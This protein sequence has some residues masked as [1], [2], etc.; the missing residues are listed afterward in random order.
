MGN[1]EMRLS[2][3]VVCWIRSTPCRGYTCSPTA[4]D[5][6]VDVAWN[7]GCLLALL[8]VLSEWQGWDSHNKGE[9][10]DR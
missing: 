5:V 2:G 9:V 4:M 3:R 8:A 6:D 7:A 10:R 1:N